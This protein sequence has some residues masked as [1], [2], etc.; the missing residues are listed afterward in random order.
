VTCLFS[1]VLD[2]PQCAPCRA[3]I[4]GTFPVPIELTRLD[5][6]P[7]HALFTGFASYD[8]VAD[9]D[10]FPVLEVAGEIEITSVVVHPGLTPHVSL[11]VI[12]GNA[13]AIQVSGTE[14]LLNDFVIHNAQN[15]VGGFAVLAPSHVPFAELEVKLSFGLIA[16]AVAPLGSGLT[17]YTRSELFRTPTTRLF[18]RTRKTMNCSER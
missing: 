12:N 4:I 18:L 3:S 2:L 5:V 7:D 15:V 9:K 8:R 14:I 16:H 13:H 10:H 17:D 1:C 6:V 11:G